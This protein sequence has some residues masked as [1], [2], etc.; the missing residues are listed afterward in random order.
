MTNKEGRLS[1]WS[2]L[3]SKGG[4]SAEENRMAEEKARI[5][6]ETKGKPN[7]PQVQIADEFTITEGFPANKYKRSAA[8]MMAPL[9]GIEEMD[10]EFEAAPKEALAMLSGEV[11]HDPDP[12]LPSGLAAE[13]ESEADERELT[14]E[15]AEFVAT[16]PP[17]ETLTDESDFAPFMSGKVPE[18]IRRKALRVLWRSHPIITHL[19]GMNDYDEDYNVIDTLID[20]ATQTSYKVGKGQE[21]AMEPEEVAEAENPDGD[22]SL[23]DADEVERDSGDEDGAEKS[24]VTEEVVAVEPDEE[25]ETSKAD[26]IENETIKFTSIRDVRKPGD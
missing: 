1:R 6:R 24:E 20:A 18:F 13:M 2:Q 16:L 21:S 26:A 15:E 9:G 11:A 25:A 22:V 17:L 19:D 3:K 23:S 12:A 8:P 4:A 5:L 14:P 10:S 7:A